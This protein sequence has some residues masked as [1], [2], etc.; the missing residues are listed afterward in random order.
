MRLFVGLLPPQ[1]VRDELVRALEPHREE[2]PQL[3]WLNPAGWH[4]TLSFLGEVPDRVLPEL[5]TR[6]ARATSRHASMT[7]SLAGAGAFPSARRARIF[8]AGVR[9]GGAG[10]FRLADSLGAGARRAGAAQTDHRRL[11]PHL[12]LARCRVDADVRSLVEAFESFAGAEW[13]A[14]TVHLVR[15]HLGAE[16]RYETIARWHLAA[17][18]SHGQS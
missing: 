11:R 13:E 14:G 12:S 17:R 7:L 9:G 8:L 15:S 16:V 3:R 18:A 1:P 5:E 6:L 4:V 10:L 2:W